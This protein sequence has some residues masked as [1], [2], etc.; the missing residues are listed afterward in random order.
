MGSEKQELSAQ[1]YARIIVDVI[2]DLKGEDIVLMDLRD[3]TIIS[4]FFVICTA[5]NE[6][7][8][9]AIVDKISE[10][11]KKDYGIKAWRVEGKASGGWILIDYVDVVVHVFSEEQ[12]DYYD[13]EGL[14]SDAKVLLRMQ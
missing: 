9:K 2:S 5:D 1:E 4:D 14:W 12:R 11:L 3:V 8:L 10:T 6:R 7:Q 13:L